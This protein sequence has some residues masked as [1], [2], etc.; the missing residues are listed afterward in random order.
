MWKNS[1]VW[2]VFYTAWGLFCDRPLPNSWQPKTVR[3]NDSFNFNA[4]YAVPVWAAVCG[5]I[6]VLLGRF[7][8]VLL[9]ANG[10]ALVFAAVIVIAGEM[11]TS[12]RGLALSVTFFEHILDR[13]S[14]AEA[15]ALRQDDLKQSGVVLSSLLLAILMPVGKFFAIY[16]AA[17]SGSFGTASAAWVA[18]AGSEAFLAARPQSVN[19]PAFCHVARSEYIAVLTVFFLLFNLV[20]LPSAVLVAVAAAAV[21]VMIML[22]LALNR[23]GSVDSNDMTMTGYLIELEVWLATA[24]LIG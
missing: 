19:V 11:R 7:L 16:L 4:L 15:S 9:P 8:S 24:I 22:N 20:H 17:R 2:Q 5:A 3:Q 23:A 12:S 6:A 21:T 13:R 1:S 10:T 14:F 18:A